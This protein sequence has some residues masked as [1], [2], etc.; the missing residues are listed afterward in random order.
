VRSMK[1]L[2]LTFP[3]TTGVR[4]PQTGGVLVS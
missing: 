3:T 1:G 4:E 2:L